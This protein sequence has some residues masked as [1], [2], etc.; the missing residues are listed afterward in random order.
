MT[1][2]CAAQGG[3]MMRSRKARVVFELRE[4]HA[5]PHHCNSAMMFAKKCM[6]LSISLDRFTGT[7]SRQSSVAGKWAR[8]STPHTLFAFV[9]CARLR[10]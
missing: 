8:P 5:M 10:R 1:P 9:A 3:N 6:L 2:N 7:A 4:F